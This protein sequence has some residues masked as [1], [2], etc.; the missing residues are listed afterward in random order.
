MAWNDMALAFASSSGRGPVAAL[1]AARRTRARTVS[2]HQ[3]YSHRCR[4]RS[5][6]LLNLV[7]FSLSV[8]FISL[9]PTF[10]VS[11]SSFF[12]F[13]CPVLLPA[14]FA[15]SVGLSLLLL[16]LLLIIHPNTQSV[17]KRVYISQLA[18]SHKH[19][20]RQRQTAGGLAST[21]QYI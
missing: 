4:C 10:S 20:S 5:P 17:M 1:R 12:F 14:V 19:A 15:C 2:Q 18:Y 16:L 3:A 8:F 13:G 11:S 9:Y 7:P 21:V 6:I